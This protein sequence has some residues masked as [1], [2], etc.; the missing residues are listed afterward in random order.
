MT[1]FISQIIGFLLSIV[2]AMSMAFS[3]ITE[4][5]VASNFDYARSFDKVVYE[6]QL[7][8][9]LD[10]KGDWVF[11][12]DR[13]LK[14]VQLTDIHI[15]GGSMSKDKDRK[16][17]NAVA[18]LLTYEKPDLVVLTGDMVYPV[19]FQAGTFNNTISTEMLIE[20]MET[21]GVYY[22]PVFGNHDS[23]AYSTQ[24]REEIADL[25]GA[26]DLEYSLFQKGP[27]DVDGFGNYIIK[28][29][30]SEG[31]TKNAFFL[32][33]SHDYTDGDILGIFWKYDNIHENQI[34]WYKNNVLA[35]DAE[36]K[37]INPDEPMFSSLAFFHIPLEEY[38]IA[39][40][41]YAANG[42][43]DT[44]NVKLIDGYYHEGDEAVCC[45]VYPDNFFETILE[46]GS[47][48]GTFAG[49]DHINNAIVEY[50]GVQLVYGMSIDYLAYV[51]P[52]TGSMGPQRG[53][54]VINLTQDGD[55]SVS[56][57][58]Y[59]QDKYVSKYEKESVSM[60]W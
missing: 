9:E 39:W 21:L 26:E 10:E 31:I 48:K 46:L 44:E 19:P 59:Y 29:E 16:A 5:I 20:L 53:C 25:W 4:E 47:T 13:D 50:K 45:G 3:P 54:T 27:A 8:P 24:S 11:K 36:N 18:A 14:I 41:E 51:D 49:H 34:E 33:D 2:T 7:V 15:G 12:T 23:E 43:K 17:M 60:D 1:A 52:A 40:E 30:N 56:L 55:L 38:R 28:V 42:Y 58:N 35:I 22:A 37:A 6:N 57:E 32:L